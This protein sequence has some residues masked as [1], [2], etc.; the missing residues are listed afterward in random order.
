LFSRNLSLLWGFIELSEFKRSLD[1]D[2]PPA[3]VD[4]LALQ[5]LWF[6]T[7]GNWTRAHELAQARNDAVGAWVHAYL[8]RA[9]GDIPNAHYWY[10][11]ASREP[12]SDAL[13]D[14]WDNIGIDLI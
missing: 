7:K 6:A 8:H 11:R 4:G 9:E 13:A 10:Q 14:E 1:R 2:A 12:D 3:S 5:A